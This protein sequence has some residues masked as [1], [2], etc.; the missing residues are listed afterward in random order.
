M[1]TVTGEEIHTLDDY[2]RRYAEYHMDPD[3]MAAHAAHPFLPSF[4][5]H[6]VDNNWAGAISEEDGGARFPTLVP[7]EIFA[8]RKQAAFQAWYENMPVRRAVLP[9]G[10]EI[11]AFRRLRYGRL[12][13][14]HVLDTRSF[15]DDQPCGDGFNRPACAAVARADAQMLGARQE[16][17]LL[18][19]LGAATAT[20]QVLA[21]QVMLSP[22]ALPLLPKLL[23][24]RPNLT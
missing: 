9:R 1:R 23:K 3:L 6:E 21:Q 20:W 19:G 10:P 18:E 24:S 14:I 8:L 7:P 16:A 13:E 17:W 15:R 5:D 12:A 4:D 2:R 22:L 11:T